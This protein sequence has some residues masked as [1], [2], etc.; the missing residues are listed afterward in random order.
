MLKRNDESIALCDCRLSCLSPLSEP[1][2]H[3]VATEREALRHASSCISF[4]ALYR[5]LSRKL[6]HRRGRE[7]VVPRNPE[8]VDVEIIIRRPGVMRVHDALNAWTRRPHAPSSRRESNNRRQLGSTAE[9]LAVGRGYLWHPFVQIYI[10]VH[11]ISS[12]VAYGCLI[13]AVF[14]LVAP[15]CA[16]VLVCMQQGV[17]ESPGTIES[18]I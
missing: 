4:H 7:R 17:E 16:E 9:A 8:P 2:L 10:T 15:V 18:S 6:I 3:C 11:T 5:K 13:G 14:H 12:P 1:Q